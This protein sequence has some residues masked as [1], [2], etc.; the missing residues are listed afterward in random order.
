MN[1]VL[2]LQR[3]SYFT[4]HSNITEARCSKLWY[5]YYGIVLLSFGSEIYQCGI[6]NLD[7]NCLQFKRTNFAVSNSLSCL[8]L[9]LQCL[10]LSAMQEKF[11]RVD[12]VSVKKLAAI[13]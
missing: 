11:K 8:G 1:G 10:P 2:L 5:F 13:L 7:G 12:Y 3:S 4:S 6:V 9:Q